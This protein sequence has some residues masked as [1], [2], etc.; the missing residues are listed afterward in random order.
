MKG[1]KEACLPAR[2]P[3][4]FMCWLLVFILVCHLKSPSWKVE[5]VLWRPRVRVWIATWLTRIA[6]PGEMPPVPA[7][8]LSRAPIL[9]SSARVRESTAFSVPDFCLS[10]ARRMKYFLWRCRKS[11]SST[12][13]VGSEHSLL[14]HVNFHRLLH[15][16]GVFLDQQQWMLLSLRHGGVSVCVCTELLI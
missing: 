1:R 3:T 2:E 11:S 14:E 4:S 12:S 13:T 5:R 7:A 6:R 16:G 9:F 8:L 10:S 15:L